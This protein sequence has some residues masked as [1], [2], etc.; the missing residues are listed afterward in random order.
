[1]LASLTWSSG[2]QERREGKTLSDAPSMV[3][4]KRGIYSAL[5]Y[6]A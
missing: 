1:M 2:R 5:S 6:K 3:I 4:S